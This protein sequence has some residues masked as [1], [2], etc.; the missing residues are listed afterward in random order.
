[1]H[2]VFFS[3][4]APG[5]VGCDDGAGSRGSHRRSVRGGNPAGKQSP[6]LSF[7]ASQ[8]SHSV[9]AKCEL[10]HV[11]QDEQSEKGTCKNK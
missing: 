11:K 4:F 2:W 10:I 6:V 1:M 3:S 5:S 9:Q 8:K 7:H